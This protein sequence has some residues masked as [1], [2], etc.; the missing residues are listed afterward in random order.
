MKVLFL[1]EKNHPKSGGGY[2]L[3]KQILAALG[4]ITSKHEFF[5]LSTAEAGAKNFAEIVE[6]LNID[7]IW[8]LVP[9]FPRSKIPF[10]VTVWDIAHK[11]TPY[12]PEVS[13]TGW[14]W[15]ER[16]DLYLKCLPKATY[17]ITGTERGKWELITAYGLFPDN[18]KVLPYPV[19]R[20]E[21]DKT[22]H[23]ADWN[24]S[25]SKGAYLFY[26]AQ[27]WPHKNHIVLI[28]ALKILKESGYNFD[29]VL[30][31]SDKGNKAYIESCA[32]NLGIRER[33][34][35]LGFVDDSEII[36]LYVNA[37]ATT[38]SSLLGPNNLPPLEAIALSCPVICADTPGMKE[39]LKDSALFF[40]PTDEV[41]LSEKIKLLSSNSL[42]NKLKST[43]LDLIKVYSPS[44]YAVEIT[45]CLDIFSK[46][47]E[48][49]G[50]EYNY[51][52]ID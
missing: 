7:F 47:R 51:N 10:A 38:Y 5:Y 52:Y 32:S 41:D 36:K 33:V 31:G 8:S 3:Q 11:V 45:N 48:C 25:F 27:F 12:F 44:A 1:G 39:Q 9:F 19:T 6:N 16:E 42:K 37:Y 46:I 28:K 40:N 26:P 23:E 13:V 14:L 30:A 20:S 43:G 49:W 17:V 2:Y 22:G 15:E 29:L 21:L 34:H 24:Y 50:I 18:I 35:F 4:E